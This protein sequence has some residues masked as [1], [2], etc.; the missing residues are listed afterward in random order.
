MSYERRFGSGVSS[1]PRPADYGKLLK[2]MKAV[3]ENQRRTLSVLYSALAP[4]QDQRGAMR[5]AEFQLFF[6]E[7]RS[8]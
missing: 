2:R 4:E 1:N 3:E 8:R 7:R 5:A 6:R